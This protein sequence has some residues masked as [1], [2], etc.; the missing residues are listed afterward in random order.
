MPKQR[1]PPARSSQQKKSAPAEPTAARTGSRPERARPAPAA[2]PSY[3][4]AVSIYERGMQALQRRD[5]RHAGQ[6][7]QTVLDQFP[8]ERELHE[9]VRLYLK[10]CERELNGNQPA[11]TTTAEH[12]FAATVALN[13]GTYD[14]AITHLTAAKQ[15]D[16][17]NDHAEYMLAVAYT[18]KGEAEE[19]LSHLRR[20]IELNPE[21]RL[22]ARQDEDLASLRSEVG[23]RLVLEAD[24]LARRRPAP[25]PARP[26][27]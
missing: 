5:F 2:R 3:P 15:A 11:P 12:L 23:F 20:A 8:E 27:R 19:G 18:L 10:V 25:A 17:H 22:V 7:F 13:A 26:R 21:N 6:F 1:R 9:R 14:Q 16:P 4:E 24:P